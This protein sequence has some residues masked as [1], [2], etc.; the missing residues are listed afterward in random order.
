MKKLSKAIWRHKFI[1]ILEVLISFAFAFG[2]LVEKWFV[3]MFMLF[4]ISICLI[5]Y[6][7]INHFQKMPIILEKKLVWRKKI[8][9]LLVTLGFLGLGIAITVIFRDFIMS[10]GKLLLRIGLMGVILWLT[11]RGACLLARLRFINRKEEK[12]Q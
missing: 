6:Y 4:M 11:T 10:N 1:L 3:P 9:Y 2:V 5:L 8:V 12:K 7:W